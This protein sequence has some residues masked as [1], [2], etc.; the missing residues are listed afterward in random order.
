MKEFSVAPSDEGRRLDKHIMHILPNAPSSFVYKMLRKKNIVLNDAKASGNE[1]LSGGDSIR[2]YLSDE[3]FEKFAKGSEE[4][5]DLSHLMPP[6]IYEDDDFLIV[7]KPSG[8]LSQRAKADDTSLNEICLSY[9]RA[10]ASYEDSASFTPSICNRL[11][12][13]TSGIVTFAKTYRAAK[14]L[15]KAFRDHTLGKYY[16]C[17]A[18]GNVKEADLEGFLV[19]DEQTNKVR[20][21]SEKSGG[22]FIK[23]MIRPLRTNGDV[24]LVDIKLITGKTHQIRAHLASCN[25][26]VVGDPKYGD[27]S[28]NEKYRKSFGIRS[29]M[30]VCHKL[31]IPDDN[32]FLGLSGKTFE[33]PMPEEFEKVM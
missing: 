33:I 12:R 29:Q 23:T 30:L 22:D 16:R 15:S 17:V 24:T 11:D 13:N 18:K 32:S 1:I 19:K 27:R 3:T 10:G 8:M 5:P 14:I 4:T 25:T 20:L 2:F 7:N 26:P 28:F 6:V 21:V 9:V 31:V